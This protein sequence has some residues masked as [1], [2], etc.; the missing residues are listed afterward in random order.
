M[1]GKTKKISRE[2]ILGTLWENNLEIDHTYLPPEFF[3]EFENVLELCRLIAIDWAK[4][5]NESRVLIDYVWNSRC[6]F[7]DLDPKDEYT[8]IEH[9][10]EVQELGDE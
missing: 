10:F 6:V 1:I 9:F 7:R 8:S 4:P 3:Q 5:T 2:L